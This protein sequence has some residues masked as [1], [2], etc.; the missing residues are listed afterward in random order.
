MMVL[1]GAIV[2]VMVGAPTHAFASIIACLKEPAP[3][4]FV[5]ETTSAHCE[6]KFTEI[7]SAKRESS[8]FMPQ[9]TKNFQKI[10][11]GNVQKIAK[12]S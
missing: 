11:C 12:A 9:V 6:C 2:K 3:L 7:T 5:F 4:S 1:L 8:F 10:N